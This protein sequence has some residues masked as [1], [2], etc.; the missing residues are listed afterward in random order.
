M[1][2]TRLSVLA[3]V[4]LLLCACGVSESQ[5]QRQRSLN[6]WM[7]E[8]LKDSA[9]GAAIVTQRT[10][11][12]YHFVAGSHDLTELGQ[13]DLAVL[14]GHFRAHPGTLHLRR[15]DTVEALYNARRIRVI[16]RLG[17][18]GVDVAGV[19]VVDGLAHG[20]GADSERVST[21]LSQETERSV[22]SGTAAK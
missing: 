21:M 3:P 17:A 2:T 20:E 11:Y 1:N 18:L 22:A 5:L 4:L 8:S 12:P 14:A 16:E 13:A 7:I 9:V 19:Q 10:L 6:T 15:G